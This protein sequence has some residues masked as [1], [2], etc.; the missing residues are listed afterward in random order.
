[1]PRK[2]RENPAIRPFILRNVGE[3]PSDIAALTASE[4]GITR[5]SANR[6][7]AKLLNDGLLTAIGQTKARRYALRQVVDHVQALQVT[8]QLREDAVWRDHIA[9]QLIGV[10]Q[11]VLDVC[12]YG[13]TEMINNVIDHSESQR[14][15]VGV[16]M[17]A[18]HIE[19]YVYDQGVGIFEK[20]RRECGLDDAR[21]AILEL[22]KGKLTTDPSKHSGEGI[23]F[24][25]RM[26]DEYGIGSKGLHYSRTMDDA[27]WL[28]ESRSH[29]TASGGTYVMMRIARDSETTT[30]GVFKKYEDEDHSF[31]RTHVPVR[32]ARYG[33]EQLVSRS[34]AKRVLSRF[35]R[36]TEVILDFDGVSQ[37][38]QAFADE[39]FRVFRAEHPEIQ[40]W[41]VRTSPQIDAMISHV[42]S[43]SGGASAGPPPPTS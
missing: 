34:Q 29:E 31:V 27:E 22:S 26:F 6:Y 13:I 37:I 12:Q 18:L 2:S 38:G 43:S 30:A 7:L 24:T 36:F 35:D 41:A 17:N 4:F 8:P 33:N 20:I 21:H 1:M 11:N 3:H 39:I 32:L 25:S 40:V 16:K 14:C 5:V 15:T 23:F 28:I 9:P 19:L 42:T 10:P